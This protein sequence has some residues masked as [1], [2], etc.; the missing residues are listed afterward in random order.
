[1]PT[2]SN[3]L[4]GCGRFMRV[5]KNSVTVEELM[6]DGQPYKLW[7]ADLF[8]CVECGTEIIAG[9]ARQP[10]AE[11][12]QPG[13]AE[14]RERHAPVYPGRC[15]EISATTTDDDPNHRLTRTERLEGLADRGT[16]TWE[17]A[18]SER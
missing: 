9:F 8:E 13:Y 5:K 3:Y 4:C 6:E 16:D 12:Y 15:A 18:R 10:L 14:T 2:S 1:M 11:H 17:E 7:D